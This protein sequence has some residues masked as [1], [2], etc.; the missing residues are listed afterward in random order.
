MSVH[1]CLS[2][3]LVPFFF[4]FVFPIHYFV[5]V[6]AYTMCQVLSKY[7]SW[8]FLILPWRA[9]DHQDL[10][11]LGND[12]FPPVIFKTAHSL[13]NLHGFLK[14]ITI[15]CKRTMRNWELHSLFVSC[16]RWTLQ[17][18]CLCLI[19]LGNMYRRGEGI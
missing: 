13:R 12:I 3:C 4:K 1:C 18:L 10:V 15:G 11:L 8:F 17:E 5:L 14:H 7:G 9:Y 6:I 2:F 16:G 19:S